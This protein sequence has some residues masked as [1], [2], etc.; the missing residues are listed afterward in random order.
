[1]QPL[2]IDLRFWQLAKQMSIQR[3]EDAFVEVVTNSNDAYDRMD[4]Q[5]PQRIF[6]VEV[7]GL[8]ARRVVF[9]DH[10]TGMSVTDIE[11]CLLRVG[12]YSSE[13]GAA[14]EVRGYFCRGSKDITTVGKV[15][16]DTIRDGVYNQC[17]LTTNGMAGITVRE[18]P[19]TQE[20]R[21]RFKIPKDGV[22]VTIEVNE[23][24]LVTNPDALYQNVIRNVA[25]RDIM[26]NPLNNITARLYMDQEE[27]VVVR[28]GRVG[29]LWPQAEEKVFDKEYE[30][31]GFPGVMAQFVLYRVAERLPEPT[32][33]TELQYGILIRSNKT[34]HE[35]TTL[36]PQWRYHIAMPYLYGSI[37]CPHIMELM[38]DIEQNGPSK[39]N[40]FAVLDPARKGGINVDHPFIQ[41]L[42]SIP[43][44]LLETY[45]PIVSDM[46]D[47]SLV[48]EGAVQSLI[49]NLEV[50]GTELL[51]SDDG[52]MKWQKDENG[53]LVR[54]LHDIEK[55]Y[56]R[57]ENDA[58][59]LQR[60]KTDAGDAPEAVG[61]EDDDDETEMVMRTD[62]PDVEYERLDIIER[63][64][65]V[66]PNEPQPEENTRDLNE[67]DLIARVRDS[68]P[69]LKI[70]F[71][72]TEHPP[73]QYNVYR[74]RSEVIL[75]IHARYPLMQKYFPVDDEGRVRLTR[76]NATFLADTIS[77]A[78]SRPLL[79]TDTSVREMRFHNMTTTET[80]HQV[81]MYYEQKHR[82]LD[83]AVDDHVAAYIAE[84]DEEFA[85]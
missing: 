63:G 55:N 27:Q 46:I 59:P 20:M 30:V 23:A 49:E 11:D 58:F 65:L 71:S 1:M 25:L 80:V 3:L 37:T 33:D 18:A 78:L 83:K 32:F 21:D 6:Y 41:K 36:R 76:A 5:P 75:I 22:R 34:I 56:V 7:H 10:A 44:A 67:D 12:G 29:Y 54:A 14:N 38:K 47:D 62:N 52:F 15:I 79:D 40:P 4:P 64:K 73:Y 35:A 48:V 51:E 26:S 69:R 60:I 84:H 42:Y 66:N 57:A 45:L 9:I 72:Q 13:Y 39:D 17:E 8:D 16:Y 50:F 85:T 31:P 19:V 82:E 61:D 28:E 74:T 68:R 70:K 2:T 43:S 77:E 53:N 81:F 24:Y